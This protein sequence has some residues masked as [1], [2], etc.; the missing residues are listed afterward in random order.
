[1]GQKVHPKIQR[2]GVIYTWPSRWYARKKEYSK[3][4]HEDLKLQEAVEKELPDSGISQVEIHRAAGNV[5][6]IIHTSKPGIII[7]RQGENIA[8]IRDKFNKLFKGHFTINI[9]EIKKPDLDAKLVGLNIA[10]QIEKRIS[11]RKAAKMALSKCK[12]AGAL[13]AKVQASGRLNGV[14]ISRSEYFLEGKIPLQTFRADIDF[15][16]IPANTR[17]GVIG[18]K[19]WIY[20]GEIFK[21]NIPH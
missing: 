4:L 21:K 3:L 19:V 20:R 14:E 17:Y 16:Y 10:R 15:A 1:M 6:I 8:G 2:I 7:G 9:K 13:G 12:E 18:V 11:Y 5:T